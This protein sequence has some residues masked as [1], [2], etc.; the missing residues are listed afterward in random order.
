M[1]RLGGDDDRAERADL[2][3]RRVGRRRR[4]FA[5]VLLVVCLIVLVLAALLWTQRRPIA[6]TVVRRE[7]ERRG[8]AARYRV[9]DIGF[10]RQ[11]L[12][13]VVL[14]DPRA[15]D[16]VAD[17]I[18]VDTQVGLNGATLTGARVGQARLRAVLRPDG[19]VSFGQID[20]LLPPPSGKPFALPDFAVALADGRVRLST[21]YGVIGA[22][23]TGQGNL[24][25]GFV[26]QL[27]AVAERLSF[28]GCG[29]ERLAMNA[30][31]RTAASGPSFAGPVRARQAACGDVRL[32]SPAARIGATLSPGFD[33]WRGQAN[34]A[35]EA[36]IAPQTRVADLSGTI[37]F[38]GGAGGTSGTID[39]ASRAFD[40]PQ[41]DG[42]GLSIAGRYQV[43]GVPAFDGRVA[44]RGARLD[45][46]LIARIERSGTVAAATP[47]GPLLDATAGAAAQ[48]ARRFDL[49]AE[50]AA[51]PLAARID[52]LAFVAASGARATLRGGT[53]R[54]VSGQGV[55]LNGTLATGGGGLPAASIRLRHARPGSPVTGVAVIQP[56][57]AGGAR[58]ALAPVQFRTAGNGATR[59]ETRA[60]LSGPLG[61]GRV[62]RLALPIDARW[63]GAGRLVVNSDCAP[64]AFDR[65][66][67]SALDLAAARLRLCP[68]GGAMVRLSDGRIG[69]GI[70]IGATRLQGRLG[71]TP[72]TLAATGGRF[73][74]GDM[75]FTLDGVMTR[76]GSPDRVSLLDIGR[77][78]GRIAGGAVAGRFKDGEG[79][80]GNVPLLIREAAGD[81]RLAGGVLSL[82][83][84]VGVRDAAPDPRFKPLRSDDF[85][86]TLNGNAIRAGGTLKHPIK[87]VK[88]SD[89]TIVHD[90]ATGRGNAVLDVPGITFGD[91]FQPNELTRLTFGV[92]ADVKGSVSGRGDIAWNPERVSSTG[93]FRTTGTDLAAAFGPVT[94]LSGEIHFTDLLDLVSAP[95]QV[96]TIAE[97]NPGIAVNDGVV[98]YRL[99]EGQ[100][101]QIEGGRWPL[102]GGEMI[103]EPTILDFAEDRE[104]RMTFRVKGVDGGL[105][106]QQF[107]FDNLNASGVF[108]GVLPMVFD[109]SGGRIE[110][111]R[112]Q[113]R[114][115][116]NLAYVGEVS[117]EDVGF[118]GNLAFQAL[119]SMNYRQLTIEMD[120]PLAGEMLTAIRFAGVSQGKGTYS[121]FLIRRLARLP[122]VFNVR[123][124]A[125]FRS[126]IDSVQ[127]Y[128]DPKRLIERNLPALQAEQRR[129]EQGLPPAPLDTTIQPSERETVP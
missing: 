11:R 77:L 101:V 12:V 58:L 125:P 92:I 66:R 59:I 105:F 50:V 68:Q 127:N 78:T 2:P 84:G 119:K 51:R 118:W 23:L 123:I 85:R 24:A 14:G 88:V 83:G 13:D 74:L 40:L 95:G 29:V 21:P 49:S 36:V 87:G 42:A 41:L 80:I 99:I 6:D 104:R 33:R 96:A 22:K 108:D 30:T 32:T 20:R 5:R 71:S 52:R 128:Y 37:G 9:A 69:G 113:S 65:L 121:N 120:G 106:L 111:G 47:V 98:R 39:L 28:N 114:G 8:V 44:A 124:R 48:A 46:A 86:L 38:A 117:K 55:T 110:G 64:V 60:E 115:N 34:V 43:G 129:R 31:L 72:V 57:T 81:W 103:L 109:A 61:D 70:G 45:E 75:A 16:L 4:R 19:T 102:G 35:A 100:R 15:P 56:Y 63:D 53:V 93:T 107:E 67:I 26:G 89:V 94:G 27:A 18:E 25:H 10:G 73:D 112:L 82:E 17:W 90:L 116:G 126:L 62:D 79:Q 76:L 91:S 7:L 122:F 3:P 97:V 54:W 1:T